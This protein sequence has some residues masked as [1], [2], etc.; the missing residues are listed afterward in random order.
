MNMYY[1]FVVCSECN[2]EVDR[3]EYDDADSPAVLATMDALNVS[4]VE[5]TKLVAKTN[6]GAELSNSANARDL[7]DRIANK[8]IKGRAKNSYKCPLGH[9]AS[10]T[11]TEDN[12]TPVVTTSLIKAVGEK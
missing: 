11:V 1:L 3:I 7:A 6:P 4:Q 8:S 12:P 2:S 5:A 9:N 10:L